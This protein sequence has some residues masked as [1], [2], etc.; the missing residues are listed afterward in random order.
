MMLD[1]QV[2]LL[3][4][5]QQHSSYQFS[6]VAYTSEGEGEVAELTVSTLPDGMNDNSK[7]WIYACICVFVCVCVCLCLCVCVR[8][9]VCGNM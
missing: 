5:C 6:I 3:T 7:L 2:I 8:A 1:I 4:L 9:C